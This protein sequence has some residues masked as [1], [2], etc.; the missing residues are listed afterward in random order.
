ML[1]QANYEFL[2]LAERLLSD[3]HAHEDGRLKEWI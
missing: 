2:S 1:N 3:P